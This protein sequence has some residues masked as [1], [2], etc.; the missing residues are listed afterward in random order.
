MFSETLAKWKAIGLRRIAWE[1]TWRGARVWL[2]IFAVIFAF[3]RQLIYHPSGGEIDPASLG[4]ANVT[5]SRL[6]QADGNSNVVW[7]ALASPGQPTILYFHGNGGGLQHRASR[8]KHLTDP[9]WGVQMMSYRGF[10]GSS[11]SPSEAANVADAVAAYDALR[12]SGVAAHDIVIYGESIGTGVAVQVAAARPA[13][14]VVLESPYSSVADV[15][16]GRFWYLPV[17]LAIRD[18]YLSMDHVAR[19]GAPILMLHG[20]EDRIIP[21]AYA[22]KLVAA[23]PGTKRYVEYPNGGHLVLYEDGAFDEVRAWIAGHGQQAAA[24]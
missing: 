9:G 15:A 20:T 7:S 22:R 5:A 6:T 10:S 3:Q 21:A 8:I 12:A 11:G 23:V 19:V 24:R 17:R 2:V 16:A 13:R 1:V 14:A 18:P 4:L